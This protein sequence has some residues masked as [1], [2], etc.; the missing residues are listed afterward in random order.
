MKRAE[1]QT[2]KADIKH[3]DPAEFFH[4]RNFVYQFVGAHENA[5]GDLHKQ[6]KNGNN[7]TR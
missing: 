5:Q 6:I 3:E 2:L 1:W 4:G 7:P